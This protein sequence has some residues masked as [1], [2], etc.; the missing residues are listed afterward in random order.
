M[1]TAKRILFCLAVAGVLGAQTATTVAPPAAPPEPPHQQRIFTLKYADPRHVADVLGVFGYGIRA[2][3]DLHVV[4]VSAPVEAMAAVEDAIK[5]LDVP[6][7]APKDVDLIVYLIVASEQPAASGGL[8][9]ELQTV[10]D[11]LKKIFSYKSFRLLDSILLRTQPGNMANSHGTIKPNEETR[12]M[13][14]T[15]SVQPSAVTEDPIGRLIRLDNL[16]LSVEG[17]DHNAGIHTEITVR[18]G[19]R[20]VVGKSNIGTGGSLILVVTAKVTE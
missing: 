7:A 2:D 20:V 18:E 17:G 16:S 1:K 8:P 10:A 4:A 5:R 19:Q 11:E 12:T 15:F 3:R 13:S 9:P 14:Y 6:A